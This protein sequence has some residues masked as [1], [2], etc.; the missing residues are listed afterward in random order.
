M[1]YAASRKVAVSFPDGVTEI[2]LLHNPS[3][4]TMALTLIQPLTEMSTRNIPWRVN[5]AGV[6]AWKCLIPSCADFLQIPRSS[7]PPP[8]SPKGFTQLSN[9]PSLCT[10]K[11]SYNIQNILKPLILFSSFSVPSKIQPHKSCHILAA[12]AGFSNK[13]YLERRENTTVISKYPNDIFFAHQQMHFI[14]LGKI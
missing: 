11:F 9:L 13:S 7:N 2:F 6:W 12:T 8:R 14:K 4:P 10:L 5:A 3:D 1:H